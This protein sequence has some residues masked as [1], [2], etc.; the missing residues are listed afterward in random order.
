M[1][2]DLRP[3]AALTLLLLA[4]LATACTPAERDPGVTPTQDSPSSEVSPE[5]T[6]EPAPRDPTSPAEGAASSPDRL[7]EWTID[8]SAPWPDGLLVAAKRYVAGMSGF[9]KMTLYPPQIANT[10]DGTTWAVF[11]AGVT[12]WA[13]YEHLIVVMKRPPDAEWEGITG[14]T[15]IFRSEVFPPELLQGDFGKPPLEDS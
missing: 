4:V 2:R 10:S 8:G 13:E 11:T 9:D 1:N 12:D 3:R 7:I 15:S 5:L 6:S 14:G